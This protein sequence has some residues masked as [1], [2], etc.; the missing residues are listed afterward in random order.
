M[1]TAEENNIKH[2]ESS[3]QQKNTGNT[4]WLSFT[5]HNHSI[6]MKRNQETCGNQATMNTEKISTRADISQ[7][8]NADQEHTQT[9]KKKT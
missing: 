3:K 2:K 4:P 7:C 6:S 8:S 9:E 5:I 1:F